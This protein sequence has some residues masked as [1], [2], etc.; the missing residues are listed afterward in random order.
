MGLFFQRKSP[1]PELVN[2]MA[3]ALRANPTTPESAHDAVVHLAS[4]FQPLMQVLDASVTTHTPANVDAVAMTN[5]QAVVDQLLG[6]A[7]FNTGRFLISL[8]IW[9]MLVGG[10]IATEATH[11]TTSSGALF[12]FAGALFGI[13]TAFLG[14]EKGSN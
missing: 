11:L 6:G 2:L 1:S 5:A 12:G 10:A 4:N 7:T 8:S 13:V 9:A 14:S 3:T